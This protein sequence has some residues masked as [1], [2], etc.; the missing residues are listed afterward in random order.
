MNFFNFVLELA[1]ETMQNYRA[2]MELYSLSDKD[3]EELG[4]TRA[5]IPATVILSRYSNK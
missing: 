1:V 2:T 5:E 4:L 3:L